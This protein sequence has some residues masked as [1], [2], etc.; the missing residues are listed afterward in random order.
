MKQGPHAPTRPDRGLRRG[1]PSPGTSLLVASHLAY[2]PCCAGKAT[3]FE[4]IGGALLAAAD[5][6][7]RS[8]RCLAKALARID[9]PEMCDRPWA[10]RAEPLPPVLRQR[11]DRPVCDLRWR[12]VLP[13]LAEFPLEG[14][15]REA[16]GLMRAQ[17]GTPMQAPHHCGRELRRVLAGSVRA[18]SRTYGAGRPRPAGGEPR[19]LP[20]GGR[21]RELVSASSS[22]RRPA[23]PPPRSSRLAPGGRFGHL[24]GDAGTADHPRRSRPDRPRLRRALVAGAAAALR[25]RPPPRKSER[26][27]RRGGALLPPYETA[28]DPRPA[29]RR[30]RARSRPRPSSASATAST[31]CAGRPR[32]PRRTR[33]A[34]GADGGARLDLA[35]RQPRP[36]PRGVGRAPPGESSRSARSPSATA[37]TRR[38]A[39]RDIRTLSPKAALP[40]GA[41][42]L[43]RPCFLCDG[44]R[45][46]LPAFGAYTGGLYAASRRSPAA[47]VRRPC[48]PDRRP[49]R[50][51]R[52]PDAARRAPGRRTC[53]GEAASRRLASAAR[54][55]SR[56][57]PGQSGSPP[58]VR[59]RPAQHARAIRKG[60]EAAATPRSGVLRPSGRSASRRLAG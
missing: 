34:P 10:A 12:P 36:R 23:R 6:V 44:A 47:R 27:A 16:V 22:S 9:L 58:L 25:R 54:K 52:S 17:P 41:G 46:I 37:P 20:R 59:K 19:A 42:A 21:R 53:L 14:F 60:R 49:L 28:R 39:G 43:S 18:G 24:L 50:D 8:P 1:A 35:R 7:T 11:I 4:T 33:R 56:A 31:T 32:S 2:C 45:L 51:L 57:E 29:R 40:L 15:V 55:P 13:G 48:G 30:D 3:A 38:G 26:L 5:P